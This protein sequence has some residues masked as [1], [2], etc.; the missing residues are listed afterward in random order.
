MLFEEHIINLFRNFKYLF[1]IFPDLP[2]TGSTVQIGTTLK[3]MIQTPIIKVNGSYHRVLII[4]QYAFAMQETGGI[5]I[6]L[7][8]RLIQHV[9][10]GLG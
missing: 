10:T 7:D 1:H 8:T 6:D 3:M 2:E 4:T 9:V 5:L